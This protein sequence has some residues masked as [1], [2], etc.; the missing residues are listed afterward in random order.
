[1]RIIVSNKTELYDIPQGLERDIRRK[2]TIKNPAYA[3]A[4]K[5][6]RW[7]GDLEEY[8]FL[9]ENPTPGVMIVPRGFT[10]EMAVLAD[11]H[12]VPSEC[13]DNTRE[14]PVVDFQF[15]GKLRDYQAEAVKKI[16]SRRF[17]VL[18]SPTGGGKTVIGL[19]AIA[20]PKQPALIIVHSKELLNQWID[21]IHSFL[22]IPVDD[23]GIIGMG[24]KRIG[25]RVTVAMVQSLYKCA[26]DVSQH[27]GFLICDEVHRCPS[28][29]MSEAIS[30]FDSKYMLGLSAT[31]YRRDGL[32]KLINFYIGDTVHRID[33]TEL[34]NKGDI[35]PFKVKWVK[36]E[37][38]TDL[39]P[40]S[41]Y[42]AML[43]ELTRDYQRNKLICHEAAQMTNGSGI[44]MI[45]SDR[46]QHCRDI[47]EI[48]A[49]DHGITPTILT[50]D[51]SQKARRTVVQRLNA[52]MCEVLVATSQLVGEGFDLP[53]LCAV[54]L[55][56]PIRFKG[57]LIQAIGRALRPSYGQ[58]MAVVV[59]FADARVGVLEAS[60]KKRLEVYRSLGAAGG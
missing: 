2:L 27:V 38:E 19:A 5:M 59:D 53:A 31:P 48:L 30:A 47:A 25:D 9:Y 21:R 10:R 60:A 37:Y 8:L 16:C 17:G 55:A 13:V 23:I 1:M 7:T 42:T 26:A 6:G 14:L 4:E 11:Q 45:L 50:G 44:P 54:V 15:N 57:R 22:G 34:T 29:Q 41:Q 36:T 33:Q 18:E 12:N 40:S 35:L 49:R 43:S 20:E 51:L 46:K 28:R 39:D 56:T 32:T 24:K 3:D 52:G 58:D